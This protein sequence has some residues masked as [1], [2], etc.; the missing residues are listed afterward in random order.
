MKL[1]NFENWV[2]GEVIKDVT[3]KKCVP[4]LIFFNEKKIEKY[5][6]N[7]WYR[8][9]TLKVKRLGDFALFDT[10]P[11][12]Q[13]SKF[14]NFLWVC[15]FLGKN[16]SNFVP[17]VLKLHNLY[18]H[19]DYSCWMLREKCGVGCCEHRWRRLC[20]QLISSQPIRFK[21]SQI[22]WLDWL[23]GFG[24][25]SDWFNHQIP[26]SDWLIFRIKSDLCFF[27]CGFASVLPSS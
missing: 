16:L 27:S 3:N 13:F 6:D 20:C 5:S 7:F 10:S 23:M 2:N 21:Q 24:S 1:L 12:T 25:D 4:K 11:L 8:K 15:W 26:V 14:N 19:N 22:Q 9:L 18:C 17:P